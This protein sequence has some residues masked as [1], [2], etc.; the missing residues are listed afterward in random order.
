MNS[1]QLL[2][3]G[4]VRGIPK[5]E[6]HIETWLSHVF[7]YEKVVRK[8]VKHV[9][10]PDIGNFT[11]TAQRR[12]FF[13]SD[14]AWNN[15]FT[16]NIHLK[17]AG[18][19]TT[20]EGAEECSVKEG[21]DFF[22]EM[23]RIAAD[24]TL[25]ERLLAKSVTQEQVEYIAKNLSDN[26]S[27]VNEKYFTDTE[28]EL[29]KS[30]YELLLIRMENFRGFITTAPDVSSEEANSRADRLRSFVTSEPYFRS[31]TDQ[32]STVTID[33]HS[34]NIVFIENVPVFM[35]VYFPMPTFRIVDK[36]LPIAKVVACIR[37]FAGDVLADSMYA[38]YAQTHP[39]PPKKIL[40]FYE[41]YNA[42]IMGYYMMYLKRPEVAKTYF[43]FSDALMNS[44]DS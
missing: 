39:L 18:I 15:Q 7:L 8:A 29:G 1:H 20:A 34:A 12:K 16:P 31:L 28:A 21:E 35:D 13:E 30:T 33:G 36:A 27:V 11:D 43:D 32:D 10:D 22:I 37:T 24:D 9:Q 17:L 40:S 2:A 4:L 25:L 38:V 26:L 19:R 3:E 42:Y 5:A 6:R 14:F 41:A 44:L 23:K